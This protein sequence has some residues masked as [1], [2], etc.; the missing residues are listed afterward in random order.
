MARSSWLLVR[1]WFCCPFHTLQVNALFRHLVERRQFAQTQNRFNHAIGY[2]IDFG[3]GVESSDSEADRAVRQIV[4][5][6][7][8]LQYIR[9]LKRRR[10]ACRSARNRDIVDAHQQRLAFDIGK[11][12][13]QIAGQTMF[14]GA[15]DVDL[16]EPA[17]DAVFQP[18]A[19]ARHF[20][21]FLRHL[22]LRQGTRLAEAGDA[23]NVEGS[24]AHA[25]LVPTAVNQRHDLHARILATHEERA[26][27]FRP[28]ELVP[29]DGGDVDVHLVH[30]DR[31]FAD[32]LHRVGV[33]DHAAFAA[34]LADFRNRLQYADF[35]V[36][37]HDRYQNRLVVDGAL[38]VIEVNQAILLHG[39]IGN[40][41]AVLLQM[42]AGI[43]NRFV[44]GYRGDDV[45]AL[46]AVHL[47]D[48]FDGEVVAFG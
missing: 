21:G 36:G 48:T 26:R 39:E 45:V 18:V 15:V 27:A 13:I 29:G 16:V 7:Q 35:V 5:R 1:R 46:L 32:R 11:T 41:K 47:G 17:H 8:S 31:H 38:Q 12:D 25:A 6:A 22:F 10:G 9:W 19:Q 14:H 24:G 40:A 44:F 2:V 3:F 4:A 34:D 30:I 37:G 23:G 20:D 42:L 28:V 43:E 33:E